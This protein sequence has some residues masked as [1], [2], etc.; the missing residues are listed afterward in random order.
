MKHLDIVDDGHKRL[1]HELLKN[2]FEAAIHLQDWE[3]LL[4]IA[5]VGSLGIDIR[6]LTLTTHRHIYPCKTSDFSGSWWT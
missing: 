4:T 3:H 5:Q 2:D 1:G 6:S